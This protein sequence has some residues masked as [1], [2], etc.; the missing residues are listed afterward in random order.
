MRKVFAGLRHYGRSMRITIVTIAV[1]LAGCTSAEVAPTESA[2]VSE[3]LAANRSTSPTL[4][5]E[6]GWNGSASGAD[7]PSN[8]TNSTNSSSEGAPGEPGDAGQPGENCAENTTY[9]SV[10]PESCE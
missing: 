1:L 9:V 3:D 5:F 8:T 6:S 10:P 7:S 2:N 4:V